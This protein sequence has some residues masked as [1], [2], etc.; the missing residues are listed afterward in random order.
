MKSSFKKRQRGNSIV[1]L[2]TVVAIV[3]VLS[4]IAIMSTSGAMQSSHSNAAADE[5]VNTLRQAR[6]IAI[7]LRR[8]VTVTFTSP[9][10]IQVAVQYLPT[11]TVTDDNSSTAVY[12]ATYRPILLNGGSTSGLQFYLFP[13]LPNT[14][15][16]PLGFGNHSAIDLEGVNGGTVGAS[17]MFTSSG[18]LVG[19]GSAT[20][21][22]YYSVGNNNP[23]NATIFIGRPGNDTTTARAITVVGATGRVRTYSYYG[24]AWHE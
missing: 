1:E 9:N 11:E 18:S 2:V 10:Q 20:P 5:V 3:L 24:N 14:P 4:S 15:M 7:T 22:N 6:Q 12:A 16:G 21:S 17:V 8:N 23:V 13:T 19:S